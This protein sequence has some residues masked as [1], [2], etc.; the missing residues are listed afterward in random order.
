M[1][2]FAPVVIDDSDINCEQIPK[3]FREAHSIKS[4]TEDFETQLKKLIRSIRS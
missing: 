4:D 2:Y 1:P 3:P